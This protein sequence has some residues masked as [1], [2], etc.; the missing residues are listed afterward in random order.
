[1]DIVAITVSIRFLINRPVFD[2]STGFL[3]C[4]KLRFERG[5]LT[6]VST[7]LFRL[8]MISSCS[9][10]DTEMTARHLCFFIFSFLR[11]V[12]GDMRMWTMDGI[13]NYLLWSTES[14]V[15]I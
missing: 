15:C 2:K 11:I 1:M 13:I 7:Q 4:S 8:N 10:D 14:C 3:H 6:M 9:M 5:F 12:S